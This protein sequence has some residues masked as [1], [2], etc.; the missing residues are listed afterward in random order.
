MFISAESGEIIGADKTMMG[1]EAPAQ[2][3][4]EVDLEEM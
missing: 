2:V 3:P 1:K 4:E